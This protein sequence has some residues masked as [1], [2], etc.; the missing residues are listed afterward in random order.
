[1]LIGTASIAKNVRLHER[2][3]LVHRHLFARDDAAVDQELADPSIY[4]HR[5]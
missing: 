5:A 2:A 1:M 3:D 4:R